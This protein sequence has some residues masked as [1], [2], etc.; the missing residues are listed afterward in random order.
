MAQA[1][2]VARMLEEAEEGLAVELVPVRTSGDERSGGGGAGV[3]AGSS[4]PPGEPGDKSR[5]VKEIE[6]AL[7][8]GEADLAVHSAKDV[9]GE[10]PEGL[11]I[12]GVPERADP[13]DALCGDAGSLAALASGARVGTSSLRRRSQLLAARPDLKVSE[14]RGNV[15]TRLRRL[16]EGRYEAVVLAR[17]GLERLGRAGEASAVLEIEEM[18]P[19]PG[20]GCLALEASA[21]D[22]RVADLAS[23]VTHGPSL[24]ALTAERALVT[25]LDATC[26]TP[27][28][29]YAEVAGDALRLI[30]FAGAPDGEAWIRDSLE[31]D[32]GDPS[33]LGRAVAERML[34]AGAG[35]VLAAADAVEQAGTAA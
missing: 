13:R 25:G 30:A 21:G 20:Q 2:L 31:G 15:D 24:A 19:A 9:P 12:V 35:D 33:A 8:A 18:T 28:G 17:A 22:R 27:V 29:A 7:L 16:A 23:A 4:A 10:L 32:A 5:F 6:E 14:L 26:R 1:R 3:R 34:A 11:A